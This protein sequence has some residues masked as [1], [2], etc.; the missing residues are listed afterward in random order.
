MTVIRQYLAVDAADME[1]AHRRFGPVD[2]L[3]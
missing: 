2:S 3:L 1:S